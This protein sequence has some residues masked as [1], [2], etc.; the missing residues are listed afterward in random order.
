MSGG[1]F[2]SLVSVRGHIRKKPKRKKKQKFYLYYDEPLPLDWDERLRIEFDRWTGSYTAYIGKREIDRWN[3]N[4]IAQDVLEDDEGYDIHPTE[5]R[6]L[7][8]SWKDPSEIEEEIDVEEY[9]K[10]YIFKKIKE[11][12]RR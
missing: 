2:M 4:E 3:A 11:G 1:V 9:I 7:V 10:S 12:R 6:I 8:Y 5:D